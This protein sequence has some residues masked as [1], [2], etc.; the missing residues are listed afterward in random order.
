MK[1]HMNSD[2][3]LSVKWMAAPLTFC[4]P[5]CLIQLAG[6]AG[7]GVLVGSQLLINPVQSNTFQL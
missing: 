1:V 7:R 6:V 4:I 3:E 5:N 2:V